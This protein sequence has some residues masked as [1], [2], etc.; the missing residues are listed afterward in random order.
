MDEASL[1]IL[2]ASVFVSPYECDKNTWTS[3]CRAFSKVG[4]WGWRDGSAINSTDR[5]CKG[6]RFKSQKLYGG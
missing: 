4:I 6:L 2:K 5:S 3:C 1:L